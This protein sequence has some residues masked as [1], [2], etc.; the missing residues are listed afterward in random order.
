MKHMLKTLLILFLILLPQ[1]S[2]AEGFFNF[3]SGAN[4]QIGDLPPISP[5]FTPLATDLSVNYLGQIFGTV[6]TVLHGTSGQLLGQLFKVFNIGILVLAGIF[7]IY[8]IIMTI[9]NTAQEGEFMGRK[10]NSAW[11]ALR[12]VLGIGLLVPSPTTGYSTIQAIVMWVVI[13][14]AGFANMAWY[15]ALSYLASGG[16]VYTPPSTDTPSMVDLVG[17]IMEMQVCMYKAEAVERTVQKNLS[18]NQKN[19]TATNTA[20]PPPPVTYVQNFRPYF[21]TIQTVASYDPKYNKYRSIVRFPGNKY[22]EEGKQDSA[23]GQISFGEGTAEEINGQKTTTLK[24]AV[25]QIMLDT[26]AYARKIGTN[27]AGSGT[28]FADQ[29]KSAVVGGAADWVNITLPLRTFGP[30]IGDALM[31]GYFKTAVQQGWI[32]AGRYYYALGE[33][34]RQ[35]N[36]ATSVN[37]T[38]DKAPAGMITPSS[39]SYVGFDT[40]SGADSPVISVEKMNE[41]FDFSQA[42]KADLFHS[43]GLAAA[44]VK[45][46]KFVA[47]QVDEASKVNLNIGSAGVLAFLISPVTAA[48]TALIGQLAT[49]VGDPIIL[50]QSFGYGFIALATYLWIGGTVGVFS[51]GAASSIMASLNPLGYAVGDALIAFIPAF[52]AFIL[53]FFTLGGT[54]AFYIP[55]IPFIIFVFAAIGWIISVIEAMVAAPLVALGITHPEGHDLLGKSEQAIMLLLSVFLRPILMIIGLIAAMILANV[56]IR[57]LNSGFFGIVFDVGDY[58]VFAFVAIIV[59]YAMLLVTIVN[60]SFSLIY[61]VPDRVMRWIGVTETQTSNVQEALQAAK[62]GFESIGGGP[63]KIGGQVTGKVGEREAGRLEEKRKAAREAGPGTSARPRG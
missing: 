8:T 53:I 44:Y 1:Y 28:N 58:N 45:A 35:V 26:D 22:T 50:V 60:Q 39:G 47:Q 31:L 9:I 4:F 24:S 36:A 3:P 25:Q 13:Q 27:E 2:F 41:L 11:I 54:M 6:G 29:V 55:L 14:G 20:A 48:L 12:T 43:M 7:L 18:Q 46:A 52:T 21:T 17:N 56:A 42:D 32:M 10:W 23:C 49:A 5:S 57:F 33:I 15:S 38:I 40:K 51:V 63:E 19:A 16:Q 62:G 34:R 37:V 30:S 59:V 61:V